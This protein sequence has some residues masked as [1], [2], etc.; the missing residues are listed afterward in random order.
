MAWRLLIVVGRSPRKPA[1][2]TGNE[3]PP[4]GEPMNNL[5]ER[6]F[7]E[8]PLSKKAAAI[9]FSGLMLPV[10]GFFVFA[11][12][13][14]EVDAS[15]R[16]RDRE[17]AKDHARLEAGFPAVVHRE[18]L[19]L[20]EMTAR[21]IVGNYFSAES[22]R[23]TAERETEIV[24]MA[25]DEVIGFCAESSD[26]GELR[27]SLSVAVASL[28]DSGPVRNEHRFF[29]ASIRGNRVAEVVFDSLAE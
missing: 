24:A 4:I 19:L 16:A 17:I 9:A 21:R 6:S 15:A 11:V 7:F 10:V 8:R 1:T 18:G 12:A 14:W 26:S 29:V 5:S 3:R 25:I 22:S 2:R 23:L 13:V 28:L 20:Q 27:G